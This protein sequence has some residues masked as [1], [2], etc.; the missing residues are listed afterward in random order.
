MN[1][2]TI[3]RILQIVFILFFIQLNSCIN[4]KLQE[5]VER[6]M[7]TKLWFPT[8]IY[9]DNIEFVILRY[10]KPT[11]CTSCELEMGRWRVFRRQVENKYGGKVGIRFI[12]ESKNTVE[13]KRIVSI[14]NFTDNTYVDSLGE[15]ARNNVEI[16]PFGKD[17]VMLL[18][19][20]KSVVAIGNPCKENRSNAL[21]DR[22]I[23]SHQTDNEN[24]PNN[25]L[26][27]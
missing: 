24:Q 14:Y 2:R 16:N 4:N 21:Y 27:L 6:L 25:S 15:F 26:G 18:D 8:N 17:V 9:N 11:S 12:I 1:D 13:I 22:I 3:A 5:D 23:N 7:D 20:K 19:E 10:I